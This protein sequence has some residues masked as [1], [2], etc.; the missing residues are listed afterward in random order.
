[1]FVLASALL[2]YTPAQAVLHYAFAGS[3][4]GSGISLVQF[5]EES[6]LLSVS[7][8]L[9]IEHSSGSKWITFDVRTTS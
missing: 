6:S 2:L 9:T 4:S 1:M 8:N 3:F 5:N 7:E